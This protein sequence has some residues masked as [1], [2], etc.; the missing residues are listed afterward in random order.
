MQIKRLIDVTG[1]ITLLLLTAPLTAAISVAIATTS[2]GGILYRQTRAG[3]HG[4]PF[5]ILKFRTMHTGADAQ[6][7][8]LAAHNETNGHLFKLRNDPRTTPIGRLLRRLSLDEL[9][10]LINVLRGD[11][12]LVGP[13]PLP[14]ADST[15]TGPARARL[16][17]RPGLTGLWQISGRSEL[18]WEE[19]IRLDLHYVKQH[20]LAL[21]L[22]ILA[23]TI[24][25]ILTTRGAH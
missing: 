10:Q 17:V 25:A 22:T 7:H 13:R 5:T 24:P 4:H 2:P 6:R 11:M 1:S 15:Y 19:M 9:P 12:S 21:D 16:S 3:H 8:T 23:R 18:P 20:S 14:L